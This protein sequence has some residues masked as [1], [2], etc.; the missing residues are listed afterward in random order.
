[1]MLPC[2]RCL[3]GRGLCAGSVRLLRTGSPEN[4]PGVRR[5]HVIARMYWEERGGAPGQAPSI[6]Y[7]MGMTLERRESTHAADDGKLDNISR[8]CSIP[9]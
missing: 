8:R 5:V 2:C 7:G 4:N 6:G 1:M 9:I 3:E